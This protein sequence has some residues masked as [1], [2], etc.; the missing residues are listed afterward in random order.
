MDHQ[1]GGLVDHEKVLILEDD[2][3]RDI[4]RHIMRRFRLW[5]VETK[6]FVAVDLCCGVPDRRSAALKSS[7][8][9]QRLQA[10]ARESRHRF[11]KGA[12]ETPARM[13]RPELNLDCLRSPHM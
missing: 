9:D 8:A 5:D 4:L 12:I 2:I 1:S 13:R 11:R 6:C 10:L 7:G 3:Q